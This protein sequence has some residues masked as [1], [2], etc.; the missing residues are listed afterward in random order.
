MKKTLT[1]ENIHLDFK[2]VDNTKIDD[3]ESYIYSIAASEKAQ[4]ASDTFKI[5]V[6]TDSVFG[7][8]DTH[9]CV[10]YMTTVAFTYGNRG[11]HLIF[12][13]DLIKGEWKNKPDLFTRLWREVEMSADLATWIRNVCNITVDVHLDINPNEKFQS[14]ILFNAAE[15]YIK[16]LGFPVELKP[17]SAIA[18]SAADYFLSY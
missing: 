12:R 11:T 13:K 3:L 14:N 9:W 5:S 4:I 2:K 18:S 16:A 7:A 10:T 17:H 1:H 15:G 8:K 6:G